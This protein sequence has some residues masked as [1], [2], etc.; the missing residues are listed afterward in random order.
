MAALEGVRE[1]LQAESDRNAEALPGLE[2]SKKV[3]HL[4]FLSDGVSTY[5]IQSK[6]NTLCFDL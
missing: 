2:Q 3:R 4:P 6:I 1:D 5:L